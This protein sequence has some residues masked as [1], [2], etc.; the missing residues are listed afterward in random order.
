MRPL[1]PI[2]LTDP[3]PD[4]LRRRLELARQIRWVTARAHQINDLPTELRWIRRM[5]FR[6]DNTFRE[7]EWGVH[8]TGATSTSNPEQ[9]R[10]LFGARMQHVECRVERDAHATSPIGKGYS[11]QSI[12][13]SDM[14]GRPIAKKAAS[15]AKLRDDIAAIVRRL[16]EPCLLVG[17]EAARNALAENLPDDAPAAHYGA[18]CGRNAWEECRSVVTVGPPPIGLEDVENL[19]RCYMADDPEPF[20]SSAEAAWP[21]DHEYRDRGWPFWCTRMRRMRDGSLQPVEVAIHP[22]PRVQAVLE[23]VR[24]AEAVRAIDRTRPVWNRRTVVAL[25][26]LVLDL[27]YD[28]CPSHRELVAGGSPWERGMAALGILPLGACDLA[29]AKIFGTPKAAERAQENTPKAQIEGIFGV[30]G[31]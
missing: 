4:G 18:L 25:D 2:G 7:S 21:V 3:V 16:P 5:G 14:F 13:G 9:V 30:G 10:H 31:I 24:E 17:S 28:A 8:Q 15:S 29:A 26:S 11:R 19:A 20:I 27:T 6:H 23:Q 12:T 22:D 1:L